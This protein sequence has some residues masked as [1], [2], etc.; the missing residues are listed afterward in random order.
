MK[1]CIKK[2]NVQVVYFLKY[3]KYVKAFHLFP[4]CIVEQVRIHPLPLLFSIFKKNKKQKDFCLIEQ[5]VSYL[6]E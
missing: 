5:A 3:L 1:Y 4:R 6:G 2:C